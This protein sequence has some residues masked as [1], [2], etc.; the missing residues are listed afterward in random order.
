[1]LGSTVFYNYHQRTKHTFEKLF[2]DNRRLDWNNEPNPFRVYAGANVVSL[3]RSM[4]A[5]DNRLF[6][7]LLPGWNQSQGSEAI[8]KLASLDAAT[9][10]TLLFHTCAISAWKAIGSTDHRWALR[11]NASSGN[12]HPTETHVLI[13]G[14]DGI[15]PG[16]YHYRVDRH[17]LEQRCTSTEPMRQVWQLSGGE[18][19]ELPPLII[20]FNSI[21]WRECWKYLERGFRYCQHDM[22]H[23]L[24]SLMVASADLGLSLD[25]RALFCDALISATLGLD[26]SDECPYLVIG[27]R[28]NSLSAAKNSDAPAQWIGTA[29]SISAAEISYD[30]I[31]KVRSATCMSE[32]Q[33]EAARQR[34]ESGQHRRSLEN[35]RPA[36][37]VTCADDVI[38]QVAAGHAQRSAADESVQTT[39]R[40]RRSAV[41][42]DGRRR[43]L[44]A[45]LSLILAG[46]TRGV[47]ADFLARISDESAR[48]NEECGAYFVDL[49]V[50]AHRISGLES[51]LYFWDRARQA[52]VALAHTDQREVAKQA[53]CFQDIAADGCLTLS[54]V[55]NLKNANEIFGERA[56]RLVHYEAG[57]IGQLLYLGATALGYDATGIGCFV[58]DA[59]NNYLVLPAGTEVIYNFCI[60]GAV[61][62]SRLTT[63]PAYDFAQ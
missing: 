36:T 41:D 6:D 61:I 2:A 34:V 11:V 52:L 26:G 40:R 50:Y 55:A 3:S 21:I 33:V 13:A 9:L 45:D 51:G 56:Y 16:A 32:S 15:E 58:D 59:I 30:I 28:G 29:N 42:M 62:D 57:I 24:G 20:C 49:Y 48:N 18:L 1:M 10:S 46:A 54:M 5:T 22:G 38:A 39:V 53:S 25:I 31:K 43:M 37:L 23:V 47:N 63:L 35:T 19:E 60:G 17:E 44:L 8:G 12:L 27:V 4:V 7:L 14:V